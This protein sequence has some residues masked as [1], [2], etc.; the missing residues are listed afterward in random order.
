MAWYRDVMKFIFAL[1]NIQTLNIFS[2]L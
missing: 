2:T 1:D